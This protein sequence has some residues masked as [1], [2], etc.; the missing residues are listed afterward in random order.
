MGNTRKKIKVIG[1]ETY[2]NQRTGTLE[3][4]QVI[5]IEDRDANFHKIWL[6]HIIH[7]MDIIGNQKIRFAFWLLDQMNSDNQ[8]TM[9]YRQM[10]NKSD[11]SLDTIKRTVAALIESNFLVRYNIGVY[12][13]NPDMIFKGGK[14]TRMNVLLEYSNTKGENGKEQP[15]KKEEVKEHE[16]GEK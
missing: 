3:D 11:I 16:N 7:S 5:S 8:I 9:T 2:I 15:E 13:V 10:A 1:T 6:E 4:M 12:Q 14:T